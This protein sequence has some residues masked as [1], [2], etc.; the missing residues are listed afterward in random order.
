MPDQTSAEVLDEMDGGRDVLGRWDARE[1]VRSC[2]PALGLFA[3]TPL[4]P[5]RVQLLTITLSVLSLA[6]AGAILGVEPE[7]VTASEFVA[8]RTRWLTR[9]SVKLH[10][11]IGQKDD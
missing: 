1:L 10:A 3:V 11:R 9:Q 6:A 5:K 4:L 2:Y 8:K 7:H